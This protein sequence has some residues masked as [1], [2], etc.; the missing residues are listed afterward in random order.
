MAINDHKKHRGS[1]GVRIAKKSPV[2]NISHNVLDAAKGKVNVR[3]VVHCQK[4]PGH[5]L[6]R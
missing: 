1:V 5:Y 2:P 3:G 6:H 4:Q